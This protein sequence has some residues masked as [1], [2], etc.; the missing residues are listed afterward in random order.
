[1]SIVTIILSLFS[2]LFYGMGFSEMLV[3]KNVVAEHVTTSD[4]NL[5]VTL[6]TGY[7]VLAIFFAV[8]GFFLFYFNNY[9]EQEIIEIMTSNSEEKLLSIQ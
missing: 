9:R 1:M 5:H 8:I 2:L 7:F 3:I 6:A 4:Y